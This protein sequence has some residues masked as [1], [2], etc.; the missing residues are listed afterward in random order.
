MAFRGTDGHVHTLYSLGTAAVGHDNLSRVARSPKAVG[1][2]TAYYTAHNDVHQVT[3]R[4]SDGHIHELWWGGADGVNHWDLTAAAEG[5]PPAKND[6]AAYYSAETNTKHVIYRSEDGHLNEIWWVPGPGGV[7]AHIDLSV[8][9]LAPLAADKPTAFAV[10]GTT[11]Q[12]VVYRGTDNQMHEIRWGS[13]PDERTLPRSEPAAVCWGP[14]RIDVFVRGT[15]DAIHHKY[16]DGSAWGPSVT[17]WQ[18]MG[19]V[20]TS[21]PAAVSWGPKRLDLFLVGTDSALH[22]KFG[23]GSAWGPSV[24]DWWSM[25]GVCTSP[26]VG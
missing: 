24:T 11:R 2:P 21:P 19:G 25:G 23:H 22:H 8:W 16:W 5:A 20:S 9:A 4:S 1:D 26:P 10:E 6:S 3:Y 7:P 18:F 17:E 12:H 15:D 14:D 13:D